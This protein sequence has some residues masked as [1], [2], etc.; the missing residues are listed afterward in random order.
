MTKFFL[1]GL[2]AFVLLCQAEAAE[3][4]Y[5]EC[6]CKQVQVGAQ[7]SLRGGVCQR[8]EAGKCLM[9]WGARGQQKVPV[10]NGQSQDEA[11]ARTETEIRGR[12]SSNFRVIPLFSNPP[13]SILAEKLMPIEVAVE[14]LAT[15]PPETYDKSGMVESFV[16]VAGTALSRF[17]VPVENLAKALLGEM[18]KQLIS[19]LQKEGKFQVAQFDVRARRGCL[20]VD[21][22]DKKVS[23]YIKTPF[24]PAESC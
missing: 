9:Q 19:A 16:L 4:E 18:R 12:A 3:L 7:S 24:A 6:T 23:V 11:S 8:T 1:R 14:N 20:Q 22:S 10:G 21:I 2:T 5:D 15:Q 17:D 13:S